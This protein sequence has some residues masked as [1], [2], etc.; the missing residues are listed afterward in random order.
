MGAQLDLDDVVHG[1]PLATIELANLRAEITALESERNHYQA[2]FEA[3]AFRKEVD[4]VRAE[5]GWKRDPRPL[6]EC[7][8]ERLEQ[9]ER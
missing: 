9:Y 3:D 8:R 7:I 2:L 6:A 4:A 1:H 5:F